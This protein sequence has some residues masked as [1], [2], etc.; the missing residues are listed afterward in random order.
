VPGVGP[1]SAQRIAFHLLAADPVD[2]RRLVSRLE[3]VKAKGALLRVCGNVAEDERCRICKDPRRDPAVLCV[4]EEPKDVVR[5]SAPRVPR[6]LPRPRRGDQ[7]HRGDRPR[8]PAGA[9][10]D[11]APRRRTVTELILATD[12]NL[13]GEATATYLARLVK[14]LG[15]RVTRLASGLPVG[16]DPRVRRRGSRSAALSRGDGCSMSDQFIVD[17]STPPT[18]DRPE[19]LH[20][21]D[22]RPGRELRR[23]GPE[24]AAGGVARDPRSRCCSSRSPSCCWQAAGSARSRT[25]SR[26]AASSPTPATT[27]T[28][29][30]CAPRWRTCS[31]PSTS[32]SRSSIPYG[33]AELVTNRL[34]DDI[35]DVVTDLVH[36]LQ[37]YRAG[38]S[39]EALWWWQFS[40]LSNWGGTAT[41]VLRA[42]QSVVSHVR[43]DAEEQT[44]ELVEDRCWPR[45]PPASR[46]RPGPASSRDR[47]D[48]CRPVPHVDDHRAARPP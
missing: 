24:V 6:S 48:A 18:F 29:R 35:A 2:V 4:V 34:S 13:E 37:H 31:S 45:Q 7:P 3:E 40:Y 20:R 12:P 25:S 42:L 23:G 26:R 30:A 32:T 15:L 28:S 33:D 46:P 39:L 9:R 43:L 27:P 22:R 17:E 38:R 47:T 1:K 10:A 11:D 44:P 21:G 16:G 36:G 14:P 19:R 41:A 8:R 5:S